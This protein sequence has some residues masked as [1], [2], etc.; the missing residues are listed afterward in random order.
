M[1]LALRE[2]QR[3]AAVETLKKLDYALDSYSRHDE[4]SAFALS[5]LTGAGKTI[6]A[7][8]V[9]ESMLMG[10]SDLEV[11]QKQSVTFLWV[12]D[13]PA[14]NR[15][16]M[17]KMFMGS[18]RLGLE[19][20][21]NIGDGPNEDP[22]DQAEFDPGRVYF[23]N[24]QKLGAK[25]TYSQSGTDLR[26][27]SL[28]DTI[29]NTI[30][31]GRTQ[32]ILVLDEAHRGMKPPKDKKTIVRQ[33]IDGR[34]PDSAIPIVWGISATVDRFTQAMGQTHDRN[35]LVPVRIGNDQIRGSGLVKD[36]VVL[37]APDEDDELTST[38]LRQAVRK[39]AEMEQ[40]WATY[41]S[42]NDLPIVRPALIIQ[43]PDNADEQ[44]YA[45]I[46]TT[47][48]SEWP[49][50]VRPREVVNVLGE[51]QSIYGANYKIE[52]VAPERIQGHAFAQFVIA[53]EAIT[54]GWDCPRAEIL[55]SERPGS[56]ETHIAQ[57]IGRILRTPLA[58]RVV[59]DERLSEVYCYLPKFNETTVEKVV[60]RLHTGDEA[61]VVETARQ[62]DTFSRVSWLESEG[63][64]D[65]VAALPSVPKPAAKPNP[66]KQAKVFATRLDSDK[67][68]SDSLTQV[69]LA[70]NSRLAGLLVEHVK[71]V[72]VNVDDLENA[73]VSE[74]VYDYAGDHQ[75]PQSQRRTVQ[76]STDYAGLR[77][78]TRKV[79]RGLKESVADDFL[80]S[81]LRELDDQ[82]EDLDPLTMKTEIAGLLMVDGV[83][84]AVEDRATQW[85][86]DTMAAVRANLRELP[87]ERRSL[88]AD[89]ETM[90][91]TPERVDIVLP[92]V[93][94]AIVQDGNNETVDTWKHHMF[95]D[96]E[97]DFA[98]SLRGW[99]RDVLVRESNRDGFVCWYR[100]PSNSSSKSALRIAY[101]L[102]TGDWTSMQ[103]DFVFIRRND[104]GQ[105]RPSVIDPHGDYLGDAVPKIKALAQYAADFGDE[106]SRIET[107]AKIGDTFRVIDLQDRYVRQSVIDVSQDDSDATDLYKSRIAS[108]YM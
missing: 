59:G 74:V 57:L 86:A 99:E 16:T 51:H 66:I 50:Q 107:I 104:A 47:I 33:L 80:N 36:R 21:H 91:S 88:Y 26:R 49:R 58:R 3:E 19:S 61:S 35:Q 92:E 71:A 108:D 95:Q 41:T 23:V 46:V 11:E 2:Y 27:H 28:W 44:K 79:F 12:T 103:P 9:I 75:S 82:G 63:I 81:R 64:Y 69:R 77:M 7:T 90:A 32:L 13:D 102:K 101:Q 20:L 70:L 10:S 14:L 37:G 78:I 56:D 48:Q 67:I 105:L 96:S 53:K 85:V 87:T 22:F 94:S 34:A 89:L 98:A 40:L 8:A 72:D 65:L 106:F 38:L 45:D 93:L 25:T 30:R 5:A 42:A 60:N 39:L 52:Y 29:A 31:S 54:T 100:N 73:D 97:G 1:D 68:T 76:Y 55:Y 24:T 17:M 84:Q 62:T 15:Q 43:V 83:I 6:I 4:R 18:G